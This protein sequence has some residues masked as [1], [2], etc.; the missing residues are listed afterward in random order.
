MVDCVTSY[1]SV[2]YKKYGINVQ[3]VCD[4]SSRFLYV[5]LCRPGSFNDV[6]AIKRSAIPIYIEHVLKNNPYVHDKYLIAD[7]A[8]VCT[9]E[10]LT[11]YYGTNL[12]PSKVAFN[13]YLSE[14]RVKIEQAFGYM[15][16]KWIILGRPLE[17]NFKNI[18][19]VLLTITRLH[20]YVINEREEMVY[21]H[22]DINLEDH[23][24]ENPV[25]FEVTHS[26]VRD[27]I[28]LQLEENNL[29]YPG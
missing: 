6:L 26:T 7:M 19:I 4:S 29:V 1:F 22:N 18:P 9:N 8:Y 3:C 21:N 17:V 23:E 25:V 11:P 2:R 5:K 14:L 20:N 12:E 24:T 27:D 10:L 16:T 28:R 15:L 13:Y